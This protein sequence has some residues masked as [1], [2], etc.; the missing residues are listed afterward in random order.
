MNAYV[1]YK[2]GTT[3]EKPMKRLEFIRAVIDS[4]ADEYT[5]SRRASVD[6]IAVAS[7]SAAGNPNERDTRGTFILPNNKEKDCVVCS[8]HR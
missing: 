4:L 8:D 6:A 3:D 5:S 7:T 1:L 2:I